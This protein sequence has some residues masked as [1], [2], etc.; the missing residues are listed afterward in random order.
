LLA[1]L[2]FATPAI[3]EEDAAA[4]YKKGRSLY[5]VSEY[6]AALDEFKQAY[7]L[8][9]DPAF[10]YNIAQCHRQ[11]GNH[12]EA[13]TFYKRFLKE[14]PQAPNRRDI[15]RM[16]GDLEVKAAK[17]EE[18]AKAPPRPA[19]PPAPREETPPPAPPP[20]PV[21]EEEPP[22]AAPRTKAGLH[23][24][25]GLG[26]GFLRDSFDWLALTRGT[27]TG[28]SG[29]FQLGATYGV[30]PNL[31]LGLVFASESSVSPRVE[32]SGVRT[33]NVSVGTLTFLGLLADWRPTPGPTGW[34][35]QLGLGGA[36]MKIE[37]KQS[38]IG[39]R[40]PVGG[41]GMLAAGHDWS[42]NQDWK[43]GFLVRAMYMA[44]SADD[45]DHRVFTASAMLVVGFR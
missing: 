44:L 19:E 37:D 14:S 5:N 18:P 39:A 28:A 20:A 13:I 30:L 43:L 23:L 10:L 31:A 25:L 34:H 24:E 2:A 27:A 8:H 7:V 41:G 4:H 33:D 3:A 35:A 40:T 1:V 32:V 9:E 29:A 6:K 26:I 16:I 12:R 45:T 15:E 38:I 11:L 21:K 36:R 22:P 17:A 42:M